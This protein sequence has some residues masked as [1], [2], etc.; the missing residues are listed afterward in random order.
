MLIKKRTDKH[1]KQSSTIT[2]KQSNNW[3]CTAKLPDVGVF[4]HT[5]ESILSIPQNKTATEKDDFVNI[6]PKYN[7]ATLWHYGGTPQWL[8]TLK[9]LVYLGNWNFSLKKLVGNTRIVHLSLKLSED[10]T[11]IKHISW[12]S[13]LI[14]SRIHVY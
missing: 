6:Q 3:L 8:R 10:S 12:Q 4:S 14:L 2:G 7:S 1:K 11:I 9:Y 5:F 13:L